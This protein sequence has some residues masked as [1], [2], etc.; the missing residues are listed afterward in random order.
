MHLGKDVNLK[1][2]A[3]VVEKYIMNLP[4]FYFGNRVNGCNFANH[5][6]FEFKSF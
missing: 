3:T 6:N 4:I 5:L 1:A 2:N